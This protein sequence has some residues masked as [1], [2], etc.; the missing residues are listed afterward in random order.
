MGRHRPSQPYLLC[1]PFGALLS[2]SLSL[3]PIAQPPVLLLQPPHVTTASSNHRFLALVT[4]HLC[5]RSAQAQPCLIFVQTCSSPD[6]PTLPHRK[7]SLFSSLVSGEALTASRYRRFPASPLVGIPRRQLS[8]VFRKA[9]P[10]RLLPRRDNVVATCRD[11]CCYKACRC[12]CQGGGMELPL[13][14]RHR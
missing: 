2:A 12:C 8:L 5:P 1:H 4:P 7:M 10:R 6:K 13:V 11:R 14:N 3:F 9:M